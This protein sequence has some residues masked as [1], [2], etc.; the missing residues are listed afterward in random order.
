ME[1]I[2]IKRHVSSSTLKIRELEKYIDKDVEIIITPISEIIINEEALL[3][4][5]V[6]AREWNNDEED[7]GLINAIKSGRTKDYIDTDKFLKA[8]KK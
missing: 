5:E 3:S 7:F 1:P 6:L 2:K 4:E 8:L